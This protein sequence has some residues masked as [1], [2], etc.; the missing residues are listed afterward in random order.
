MILLLPFSIYCSNCFFSSIFK[1]AFFCRPIQFT[2]SPPHNHNLFPDPKYIILSISRHQKKT[3]FS[4]SSQLFF[5]FLPIHATFVSNAARLYWIIPISGMMSSS[6][7]FLFLSI[8]TGFTVSANFVPIK[9]VL[10]PTVQPS[11]FFKENQY[12]AV[13]LWGTFLKYSLLRMVREEECP[14]RGGI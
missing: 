2:F 7:K 11:T 3:F 13:H 4:V 5:Y 10:P 14:T 9:L 1:W 12:S 6:C 8:I